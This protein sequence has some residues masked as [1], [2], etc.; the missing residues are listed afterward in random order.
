MQAEIEQAA[1]NYQLAL[2][3]Q[4]TIV[5]GVNRFIT[6]QEEPPILLRVD[7]VLGQRQAAAIVRDPIRGELL[8]HRHAGQVLPGLVQFALRQGGPRGRQLPVI[9]VAGEIDREPAGGAGV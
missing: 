8:R 1:Y 3:K 9:E 2:E 7:P 5:V 4:D 6:E